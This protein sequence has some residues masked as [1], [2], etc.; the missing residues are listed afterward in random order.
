MYLFIPKTNNKI[1]RKQFSKKIVYF[2]LFLII[3]NFLFYNFFTFFFKKK[4]NEKNNYTVLQYNESLRLNG[5]IGCKSLIYFKPDIIVIGDSISYHLWDYNLL[6]S[7]FQ[8]KIGACTMP[9]MTYHSIN[10][11]L[12]YFQR[13]NYMPKTIILATSPRF[14]SSYSQISEFYQEHQK[15]LSSYQ[16]S[17]FFDSLQASIRYLR[18]K[19]FYNVKT[20]KL[21]NDNINFLK[22]FTVQEEK[23]LEELIFDEK[24]IKLGFENIESITKF[25][26]NLK[27]DEQNNSHI[28]DFCNNI[29]KKNI[30]F[31]H[32][33]APL[34]PEVENEIKK[35]KIKKK[36]L[37]DK[38]FKCSISYFL[39]IDDFIAKSKFFLAS[40][41]N[42]SKIII[43][44]K[45]E[46][47]KKIEQ[48]DYVYDFLHMNSYG[49]SMFTK[50]FLENNKQE[51]LEIISNN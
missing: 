16:T 48:L 21:S 12:E 35:I 44:K 30:K 29:Q 5:D 49:S 24:I 4:I 1:T 32:V 34:S 43:F 10:L 17:K 31:I 46:T 9:G 14:F 22:N 38:V 13:N 3:F 11:Q 36:Y 18:K 26:Q 23:N 7:F 47:I 33:N 8:K 27:F 45:K 40:D 50:F 25:Y 20:F 51:L 2:I 39:N 42:P 19:I 28:I 37:K 6:D 41:D 15:V